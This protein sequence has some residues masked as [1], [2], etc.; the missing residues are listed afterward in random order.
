MRT[1]SWLWAIM[2]VVAVLFTGLLVWHAGVENGKLQYRQGQIDAL[3]GKVQYELVINE[4]NEKI[5]QKL[6]T[7]KE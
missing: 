1:N 3:N 6:P 7:F 5:W 4:D 2:M